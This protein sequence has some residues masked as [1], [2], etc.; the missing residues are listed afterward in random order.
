MGA[1]LIKAIRTNI[2]SVLRWHLTKI[3]VQCCF[4]ARKYSPRL[5]QERHILF[6]ACTRY[7]Y[8][9]NMT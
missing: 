2:L 5:Q 3:N 8:H 4:I 7:F 6:I 1:V 9:R